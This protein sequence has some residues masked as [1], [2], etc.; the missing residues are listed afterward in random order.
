MSTRYLA[1]YLPAA[2]GSN[3]PVNPGAG[4]LAITGYAPTVAQTTNQ[5][6]TPGT[7]TLTI[8]GY[9][10]T[11]SQPQTAA[12]GVGT[13][14]ITGYAPTVTQ[15]VNQAV[16]PG[17]GALTISGY[18]PAVTQS[19]NQFITPGVGSLALT[20]FAPAVTQTA[21]QFIAP[22]AGTMVITGYAPTVTQATGSPNLT[23]DAG[24]LA[25]TGYAPTVAQ[26]A[27]PRDPRFARPVTDV[28]AGSW[29]PSVVG[30]TLASMIDE[31]AADSSDYDYT[32]VASTCE[33][34]L[35][36]VTDPLTSINQVVRYQVWSPA[37]NGLTVS[38]MQGATTIA[39][40]AHAVLPAVPTI[41]AQAL[42]A[43]QCDAITNYADLRFKFTAA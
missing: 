2:S 6:V 21:N 32:T 19:A 10:P 40:W 1:E 5:S 8:T 11:I 42:T 25:L 22:G 15:A 30:A 13:L 43:A 26:A 34:A 29:L 41:Y 38:L 39:S 20:G 35:N 14:T 12:P 17:V 7:G 23:P 36:A 3:T 18:A 37:G 9:A 27:A 4:S 33:I 24:T 28:S 16:N 31:P